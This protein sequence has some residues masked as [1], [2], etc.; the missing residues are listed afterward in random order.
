MKIAIMQPYFLPYIG[1]FQLLNA[2]DLFLLTDNM[3]YTKRGWFNRN[4][5]LDNGSER[6]ISIPIK[7]A[8]HHL[9]VNQR[10][11]ANNSINERRKILRQ[12]NS[13]YAK[14]PYFND[15]YPIVRR[16]FLNVIE[17][18]FDFIYKSITEL[19]SEFSIDTEIELLS[20]IDIDHKLPAQ[21]RI[22]E[23]CK[24]L[25]AEEYINSI[26]GKELYDKTTFN[27][28]GIELKFL[29]SQ[30]IEY[31]Q[32]ENKFVPWLSIID[33]LMFNDI[34]TIKGYLNEYELE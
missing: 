14:A 7:K 9:N 10:Y 19:C 21:D 22:I 25:N 12:I 8:A 33:V 15:N 4:K 26:G 16:P 31:T 27:T 5:I 24:N 28:N 3:Q 17:N 18:L 23:V 34:E 2:V 11:L 29:R 13:L 1:Y 32:Y 6:I 20:S 30:Y